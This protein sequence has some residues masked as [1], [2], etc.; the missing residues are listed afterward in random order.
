MTAFACKILLSTVIIGETYRIMF[1][2]LPNWKF[3]TNSAQLL[4][5]FPNNKL[6]NSFPSFGYFYHQKSLLLLFFYALLCSQYKEK[7][8]ERSIQ[9]K[10]WNINKWHS[11]ED[12]FLSFLPYILFSISWKLRMKQFISLDRNVTISSLTSSFCPTNSP[13]IVLEKLFPIPEI[14]SLFNQFYEKSF[15][16]RQ[17]SVRIFLLNLIL[18]NPSLKLSLETRFKRWL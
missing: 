3:H 13:P 17:L 4:N 1:I 18:K 5:R 9:V 14:P 15:S 8:R 10:T 6:W 7:R 11:W 2:P 16:S 12:N